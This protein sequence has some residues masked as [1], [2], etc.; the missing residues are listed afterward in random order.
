VLEEDPLRPRAPFWGYRTDLALAGDVPANVA[1]LDAALRRLRP[2]PPA[3]RVAEWTARIAARRAEQRAAAERAMAADGVHAAR[4]FSALRD[5]LPEGSV[6]VDEI[7]AALPFMLERLF[8]G[9]PLRHYRGWAGALGTGIPTALGARLGHPDATTVAIV[10]DGAFH[11]TPVPAAFGL[12]QQYAIPLL[13]VVCDNRG[14]ESQTWNLRKYFP[15][16]AAVRSGRRFGQPIEPTPDYAKLAE[17]YG[18]HGERVTDAAEL[19][20]AIERALAAVASGRLALL[21]VFVRP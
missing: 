18:G 14:F 2:S 9:K 15:D 16:G 7:I 8:D 12:A 6:V 1:A 17:A 11:Y 5:A 13:V 21:D 10:G 20:P 3:A 19:A 4:L